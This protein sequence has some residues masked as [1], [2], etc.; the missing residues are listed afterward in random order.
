MIRNILEELSNESSTNKKVE[1]LG[2]YKD[3]S[4][5]KNVL[6]LANSKRIKFYIKQI[7]TYETK[8][9]ALDLEIAISK[10]DPIIKRDLTGYDAINHLVDILSHLHPDDAYIIERIIEKDCKIN[11]GSSLINKVFPKLIEDTGYMGAKSF[12]PNLVKKLFEGNKSVISQIKKDGRFC[13]AIIRANESELESRQGEPTI[14]DNAA[15]LSDLSK[16]DDCVLN[17]ELTMSDSIDRY[18][19]NG[20]IAS[21]IDITKKREERGEEETVKKIIAFEKKHGMTFEDALN[22]IEYTAWDVLTIDEYYNRKSV[23]PYEKRFNRLCEILKGFSMV[24]P[25]ESKIVSSY[26]EAIEHF[27]EM[28]IRGEEGIILKS[29]D[30]GWID[31]KPSYQIK[32]KLDITLDLKIIGFQYGKKGTKN[33]NVIS[34]INLETSDG[35]L[36]TNASGMDEDMMKFIT[37]NQEKLVGTI[38]EIKC[39]GLSRDRDGN[40][41]T[42]HPSVIKLR[43]DKEIANSLEECCNIEEMAKGL[44]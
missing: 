27:N 8:S 38:V 4:L 14:L 6:Y 13:N 24:K 18:T 29:L 10:L 28:L 39:C 34:T 40:W 26:Q 20:I 43:D 30:G 36:K 35:I 21:L 2:K 42:L 15:F 44:I 3:N 9:I 23:I 33:E 17:G 22:K 25:V 41:S 19:A 12:S 32:M 5:L 7:P 1:I 16:L 37:E 11:M 31:S